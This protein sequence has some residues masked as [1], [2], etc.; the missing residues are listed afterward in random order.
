MKNT[1]ITSLKVILIVIAAPFM[2]VP[3]ICFAGLMLLDNCDNKPI[4]VL[5]YAEFINKGK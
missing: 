3:A 2:I 4:R 5:E 1:I